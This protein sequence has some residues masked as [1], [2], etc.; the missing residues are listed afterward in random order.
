ML[1]FSLLHFSLTSA[2]SFFCCIQFS[3]AS[4]FYLYILTASPQFISELKPL[5]ERKHDTRVDSSL[6]RSLSSLYLLFITFLSFS[7]TN[8]T[9]NLFIYLNSFYLSNPSLFF[10]SLSSYHLSI[11]FLFL[12]FPT[13]ALSLIFSLYSAPLLTPLFFL[14]YTPLFLI[15]CFLTLIVSLLSLCMY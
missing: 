11:L 10:F 12:S 14:H 3:H 6:P 8:L 1:L 4:L 13:A 7:L 15:S 2:F 9:N 5:S